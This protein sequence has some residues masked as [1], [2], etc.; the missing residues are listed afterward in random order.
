MPASA[1]ISLPC[2]PATLPQGHPAV[3]PAT[4][5][6]VPAVHV[7][8]LCY[9]Y[10]TEAVLHNITFTVQ[11]GDFL[12]IIGPNGGGKSTLL[13]LLLGLLTPSQ[14][15]VRIFGKPPAA[16][17]SHMGFVPQFTTLRADFPATVLEM[18]LMGGAQATFMGGS[19]G[20]QAKA[21][22]KAL[23]LLETLGL[24]GLAG[25]AVGSLSGGQCQRAMAARALMAKPEQ[26]PAGEDT[27]FLLLL[28]E[29]TAS[30]DPE[31]KH[32]FYDFL[33]TLR[34]SCTIVL[35]SHDLSLASP[36]FTN[37]ALVNR[38]LTMQPSKQ[39]TPAGLMETFGTHGH[40]CPIGV[41]QRRLED[42]QE[43]G[44]N[45]V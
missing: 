8:D 23:R 2:Q 4:P 7:Q 43:Q 17:R 38:T 34:G 37:I 16:S 11:A 42:S 27:P 20:T 22:Q 19:W 6:L 3:A 1:P 15:E 45:R 32:C 44:A 24:S 41:L 33:E 25:R 14:G 36:Y 28:D 29:P 9:A 39:L 10:G 18:V 13:R 35:V 12:A 40:S 31:G 5:G 26:T 21:K 30:I